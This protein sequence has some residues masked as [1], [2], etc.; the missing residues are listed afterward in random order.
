MPRGSTSRMGRPSRR[1]MARARWARLAH[2]LVVLG[3]NAIFLFVLSGLVAK[4]L[5]FIQAI[6]ADRTSNIWLSGTTIFNSGTQTS[7]FYRIQY[8]TSTV[9]TVTVTLPTGANI[10]SG[11]FRCQFKHA[12]RQG[13]SI[14]IDGR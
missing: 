3:M 14:I 5:G 11:T 8:G 1:E 7:N 9:S 13:S 2:P 12:H 6:G 4:A 10:L